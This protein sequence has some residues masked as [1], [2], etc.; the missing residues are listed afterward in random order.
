[1]LNVDLLKGKDIPLAEETTE[2]KESEFL[3]A[4]YFVSEKETLETAGEEPAEKTEQ[5]LAEEDHG[6]T[7]PEEPEQ[8]AVKEET[9]KQPVE[10]EDFVFPKKSKFPIIPVVL[11]FA[12]ALIVL[13]YFRFVS[14]KKSGPAPANVAVTDTTKRAVTPAVK[15]AVSPKGTTH[16]TAK[17]KMAPVETAQ[18]TVAPVAAGLS[19]EKKAGF[20]AVNLFGK[21]LGAVP[22]GAKIAFL[23]FNS[24]YFT[25]ELYAPKKEI[26]KAFLQKAKASVPSFSY[27]IV[28]S[29]LGFYNGKK[30]HHTIVS[31][32]IALSGGTAASGSVL[33]REKA[34]AALL[35]LAKTDRVRVREIRQSPLV[36]DEKGK[37][38][39]MTVKISASAENIQK[40]ITD[41]LNQYQNVGVTRI[42]M[43]ASRSGR[44][45]QQDAALDLNLFF[46]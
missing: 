42:L 32:Q 12:I 5:P 11:L 40:F 29:D 6:R 35:G 14:N 34:K 16:Q 39:P 26:L 28:S 3:S 15:E 2:I 43:S 37:H 44:A 13:A 27:K 31:G 38:V 24:G 25:I 20:A 18:Q 41:L 17:E 4:E 1:M 9:I 45:N 8:T 30:M 23:S 19:N 33:M 10:E 46:E 21:V 22:S 7:S 36:T